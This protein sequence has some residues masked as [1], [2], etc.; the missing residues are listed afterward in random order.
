MAEFE[1]CFS[2]LSSRVVQNNPLPRIGQRWLIPTSQTKSSQL[3]HMQQDCRTC[4][5]SLIKLFLVFNKQKYTFKRI[6]T[7]VKEVASG[8]VIG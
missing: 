6:K 5:K 1:F 4:R 2:I 7:R 3:R 8:S